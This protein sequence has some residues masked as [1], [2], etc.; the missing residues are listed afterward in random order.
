M[1][2]KKDTVYHKKQASYHDKRNILNKAHLIEPIIRHRIQDSI[3][4]KQYLFLSNE[5]TI[6]PI[7][8]D[9]VKYIFGTESNGRPS[10]FLCCLLRLLELEPKKE[11]IG[12]Y[13]T[14]MGYNEFKYLTALSLIYIRLV[15]PSQEIYEIFDGYFKDSRKLRMKLKSPIFDEKSGLPVRYK[16]THMDEWV[17]HLLTK[18]RVIDIILPRLIPRIVFVQQD[19]LPPRKYHI[20]ETSKVEIDSDESEPEEE[21]AEND[22][23]ES[24]SD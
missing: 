1:E 10:P 11:I 23:Y 24:D 9:Q 15:Y 5:S 7:I 13:L 20:Q 12:A 4:Y 21:E 14:Q 18:E 2:S 3:F 6:L 16:L 17:D 8:I 22:S 19:I